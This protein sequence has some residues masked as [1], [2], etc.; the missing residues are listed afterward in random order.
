MPGREDLSTLSTFTETQLTRLVRGGAARSPWPGGQ[1]YLDFRAA[2]NNDITLANY[3]I[4]I[5]D[6]VCLAREPTPVPQ[7]GEPTCHAT[8]MEWI[9]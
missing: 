2:L 9:Y 6:A 3:L 8:E 1:N 7:P 5:I 4:S